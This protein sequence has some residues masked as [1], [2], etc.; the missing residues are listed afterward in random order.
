MRLAVRGLL[1][2]VVA[3]LPACGGGAPP[4]E[5]ITVAAASDLRPAF[6]A[7]AQQFTARSGTHVTFSFGSSGQ[8]REQ[9]V[10]GAPFDVFASANSAYVD[11][12]IAAGRASPGTRADYGLGRLVLWGPRATLV[13]AGVPDLARPEFQRIAIA[14]PVHAPYG[15]AA[16]Q[17][18]ERAGVY[19]AVLPRLVYGENISDTLRIARSGNADVAIVALS[20]VIVTDDAYTLVPEGLHDPLRQT[21]V[22]TASG[23]RKAAAAAFADF[24]TSSAGRRVMARYGFVVPAEDPTR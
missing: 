5:R 14:N 17:V 24:V 3:A 8:L 15:V 19:D 6:E 11:D 10:N 7:V 18:L 12:V 16:K 22:V 23:E 1:A 20:L 2:L 9:I 21:L 4:I 13:P